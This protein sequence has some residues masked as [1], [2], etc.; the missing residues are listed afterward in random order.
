MAG[1]WE[2]LV[3]ANPLDE[4]AHLALA[5]QHAERG[6]T[7]A[8]LRQLERMDQALRR[9]LGTVPSDAMRRLRAELT[10]AADRPGTGRAA[11]TCPSWDVDDVDAYLRE[12]LDRADA[13]R[14]SSVMVTGVAGVGQDG[15]C[16]TWPPPSAAAARLAGRPW[17]RLGGRG[18]LALR[19]GA[20]GVRGPV[21]STSRAAGRAGRLYSDELGRALA[22]R[23]IT[24]SGETAH[25]RLFVAAAELLRLSASG[26]G[27]L[28]LVD[29][30]HEADEASLRLLHY[31]A[32]CAVAEPVVVALGSRPEGG[33]A[34]R[35]FGQSLVAPWYRLPSWS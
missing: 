31:L 11:R 1:C 23:E 15:R 16:S 30:V 33:P 10:H 8:A 5:R 6:D 18:L 27:L 26:H 9:E 34:L 12:R 14:G 4:E 20:R 2:Q 22:G 35:E 29:D 32:R 24:W 17:R 3:R 7:R 13:G 21:P 28:L 19:P 25:Q